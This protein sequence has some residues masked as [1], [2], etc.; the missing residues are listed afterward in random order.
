MIRG[1]VMTCASLALA[2]CTTF[3]QAP[4]QTDAAEAT[5]AKAFERFS[6][7]GRF[8]AKRGDQQGSGQFR[9]EQNGAIRTLDL[10]TPAA[11]QLARI[12]ASE[13]SARATLSNGEVREAATLSELL[14]QFIDIPLT[15]AE[16]SSWLQGVPRSAVV[17]RA[18]DQQVESFRESGWTIVVNS[19]FDGDTKFVRRMRWS[20]DAGGNASEDAQVTWVFDEFSTP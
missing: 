13:R 16:F 14:R 1:V 19:R 15:D 18:S 4:L 8:S 10:F 2:G 6:V 12:E 3:A 20:F 5:V 9:Y 11:T 7:A 17:R